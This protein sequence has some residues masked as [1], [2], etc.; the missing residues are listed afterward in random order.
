M[1][2][3][4][5][6]EQ[7]ENIDRS[8]SN[9]YADQINNTLDSYT[10]RE[11]KYDPSMD[12]LYQSYKKEY[13]TE[14]QKARTGVVNQGL[15][16]SGG[17]GNDYSQSVSEQ[18]YER[19]LTDVNR[20][21]PVFENLAY[22]QYQGEGQDLAN[23]LSLLMNQE[24]TD[25]ARNRD[26]I[27]QREKYRDYL[28]NTYQFDSNLEFNL[29]KLANSK[30]AEDKDYELMVY[31]QALNDFIADKQA[32]EAA[33][34]ASSSGRSGSGYGSGGSDYGYS[35]YGT[36]SIDTSAVYNEHGNS[37]SGGLDW[38]QVAGAGRLSANEVNLAMQSG[39]IGVWTDANGKDHY[40]L[41]DAG[42]AHYSGRPDQTS[43]TTTT[44]K[45]G[46]G[47]FTYNTNNTASTISNAAKA[48]ATAAS[49]ALASTNNKKTSFGG[50]SN[51]L[52]TK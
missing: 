20:L 42:R 2:D 43:T 13:A 12:K 48:V 16:L 46:G 40:T 49:N 51:K 50:G 44:N 4:K 41:T 3:T 19:Y 18:Q 25:Y 10:G 1:A 32:K 27:A 29:N 8:Y 6:L 21:A 34:R 35:D 36:G 38:I 33:A 15:R 39:W 14:A 22:A 52:M 5:K 17:Y 11:Y 30:D 47:G 31:K 26:E 37:A 28:A 9:T 24:N 7:A 23:Q 45:S